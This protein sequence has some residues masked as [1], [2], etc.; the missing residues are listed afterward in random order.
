M[1]GLVYKMNRIQMKAASA[2]SKF[3]RSERGDTN[4]ISIIIIVAIVIA[5]AGIFW[6]FAKGGMSTISSKFTK[7]ISGLG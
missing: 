1:K 2:F 7:F 5:L 3:M 6:I 4:F